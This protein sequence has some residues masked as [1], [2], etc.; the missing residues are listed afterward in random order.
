[1]S[2]EN[3]KAV[4]DEKTVENT[5]TPKPAPTW[6]MIVG[7]RSIVHGA[8]GNRPSAEERKE[9]EAWVR[10][11]VAGHLSKPNVV[12]MLS[13]GSAG[14]E[15]IAA[16]VATE[17]RID[18]CEY[19]LDGRK[20]FNDGRKFPWLASMPDPHSDEAKQLP[21]YRYQVM[22]EEMADQQE[23]FGVR[24]ELLVLRDPSSPST[25]AD[26]VTGLGTRF[27]LE[28]VVVEECPLA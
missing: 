9:R 24:V 26:V 25:E 7:Q 3:E 18:W 22:V 12:L 17:L 13:G 20:V 27:R 10:E 15:R 1:M 23:R 19:R 8:E 2:T 21:A 4:T 14:P 16:A 6:V 11:T 5:P 28:D